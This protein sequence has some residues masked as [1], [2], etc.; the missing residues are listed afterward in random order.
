MITT[1]VRFSPLFI[2]EKFSGAYLLAT[3]MHVKFGFSPLFIGEKFSGDNAACRKARA[4]VS[5]PSSSG[6]N[7]R[8][9]PPRL[10]LHAAA[11]FQS[12]LHPRKIPPPFP[13]SPPT[14]PK[15]F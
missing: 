9:F 12:P 4:S 2:G 8:A 14:L 13:I 3:K 15:F 11:L 1:S 10:G 7:S 6:K 5:V